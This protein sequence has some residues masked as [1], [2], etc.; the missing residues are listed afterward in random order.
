MIKKHKIKILITIILSQIVIPQ[1]AYAALECYDISAKNPPKLGAYVLCVLPGIWTFIQVIFVAA[2]IILLMYNVAQYLLNR[3]NAK[4]LETFNQK[5]IFLA[6][7]F[8]LTAGF[9]GTLINIFLQVFGLGTI[10][11]YL[12]SISRVLT[13]W[14]Q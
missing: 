11:T 8:L 12:D 2:G 4:F 13:S 6:A 5:I 7:M 3:T 10:N 14:D 9:G 1:R